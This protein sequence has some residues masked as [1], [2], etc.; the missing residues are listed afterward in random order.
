MGGFN[1][2]PDATYPTQCPR[3]KNSAKIFAPRSLAWER[4]S[5]IKTPAPSPRESPRR[6]RSKGLHGSLS[7]ALMALK[8]PKVVAYGVA[9]VSG[10]ILAVCSCT[11]LPLFAGIHTM[12]AG[13]G[14]ATAFL[15]SGPAI[16]VLAIVL[17]EG[18]LLGL[19]GV[20]ADPLS[21]RRQ[22]WAPAPR[23]RAP[24]A[25]RGLA[26]APSE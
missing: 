7:T 10:T 2:R 1:S 15:Y 21:S 16:N 22:S 6:L 13:L 5:N 24:D 20:Q 26:Q 19:L 8:A 23:W 9:S 11:V 17:T 3:S 25:P 18:A 4:D 14:P 12:G